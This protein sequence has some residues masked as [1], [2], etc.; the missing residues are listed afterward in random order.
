MNLE[1]HKG[2]QCIY[3]PLFCQEGF[4]SEC[5]Q[6]IHQQPADPQTLA[7]AIKENKKVPQPAKIQ[8]TPH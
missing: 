2:Q 4:C 5:M 7:D 6:C 3:K 8:V 1:Y